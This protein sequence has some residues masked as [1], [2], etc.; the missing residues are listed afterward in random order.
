MLMPEAAVNK[1]DFAASRENNIRP[2]RKILMMEPESITKLVDHT[3]QRQLRI[4]IFT[5]DT[6]HVL[7][8]LLCVERIHCGATPSLC[9]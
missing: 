8:P 6:A 7:A 1:Y 2:A 9:D 3:A 5:P 4:R